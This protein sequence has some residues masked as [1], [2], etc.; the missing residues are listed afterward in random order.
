[1]E[2]L[3]FEQTNQ[4]GLLTIN[5]EK[6]LNAL[7][8]DLLLELE[9]FLQNTL[10]Q[11]DT[12]VLII[13]GA[14]E[15]AFIAGADI[16]QMQNL[17][18]F[19]MLKFCDL[20][21]KVGI[22]LETIDVVTIAAVNGYA[23]GGGLEIALSCD[24]IYASEN[25]KLGLP[26]VS[27]GL[28]P[29]FGGTQRL[30]RAVGTRQAKELVMTGNQISASESLDLGLVNKV[31][32]QNELIE[33]CYKTAD[34]IHKNAFTAVSQSKRS[35]NNGNA[36]SMRDALEL[37]KQCCAVC[38]ASDDRLEGMTAFVEKRLAQFS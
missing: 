13:T 27:L 21:Q 25:A 24:F 22:L 15:K 4:T 3:K 2:H 34:R 26:E 8:R 10:P 31:F 14:G 20:G 7:N 32:P 29:G 1:V 23:L 6:A 9:D 30:L 12:R 37:E 11:Q 33:N 19:E 28:I 5:R 36:L 16:K 18:H 17:N 38:F 35:I